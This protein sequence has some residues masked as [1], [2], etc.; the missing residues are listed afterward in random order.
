MLTAEETETESAAPAAAESSAVSNV[1]AAALNSVEQVQPY[2]FNPERY[3]DYRMEN[4]GWWSLEAV[5]PIQTQRLWAKMEATTAA[6]ALGHFIFD[7]VRE[8]WRSAP[9]PSH[10]AKRVR[11]EIDRGS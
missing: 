6:P 2:Q 9:P 4:S 5:K 1:P 3:Q 10:A 8:V 7:N 11:V